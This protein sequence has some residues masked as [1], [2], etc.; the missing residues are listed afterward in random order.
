M[1]DERQNINI[2]VEPLR[3]RITS[4]LIPLLFAALLI[5]MLLSLARIPT[6]GFRPFMLLHA[7]F[8]GMSATLYFTRKRIRPDISALVMIGIL[9][10]LL[11]AGVASLG[12][13]SAT[14]VLGPMIALYLMLLG[15]RKSA[16]TSIVVILIYIS[17][18]GVLFVT[19]I[20]SSIAVPNSYSQSSTAWMLML[21]VV[22]SISVAAVSPFELVHGAL[23]ESE[24]RSRVLSEAAFEGIM[25]HDKGV[26]LDA[27][28][29]FVDLFGFHRPEDLIGLNGFEV[30]PFT[31][32][33]LERLKKSS[34]SN[35]REVIEITA[36]KPDGVISFAE[37]QGR[38]FITK[39][40]KLRV[41]S[42]RDITERKRTDQE[43]QAIYEIVEGVTTSVNLDELFKLIHRSL[44]KV[45]YVENCF[46]ALYDSNTRLFK[47]PY[48]VDKF[49]STPEPAALLKSCTSYVFRTGK[50]HLIPQAAFDRL[51]EQGE[52]ELVGSPSPSWIGVPLQTPSKTIGV[53]VLQHYEKENIYSERDL[54]FLATAGSEV[55][56]VI[57]RKLA[58]EALR[59]SEERMRAIVEGTPHLFFYTQDAE[60]N[61]T[62]VSPT[63]EQITGYKADIWLKRKDWFI[64]DAKINQSAKEKTY[65]HLQGEFAKEPTLIEVRHV[66][67]DP[68]LL[69]AYEYP[70]IQNGRVI[71]L[72]GV[73]H[74]ITKRKRVE[75][76]LRESEARFRQLAEVAVEGIAITEK[77]IFVD[78]NAR[79][80]AMLGY[81]LGEMIGKQV[82]DFIAPDSLA[83]VLGHISENYEGQY[84][85]FLLRKDGSTFPVES[86]A[87]TMMWRGRTMRV[88]VLLDISERKHAE[89]QLQKL[90]LAVGQSTASIVITDTKGNIEYVNPKFTQ[91]TGYTLEEAI[92]KNPRILK[93]GET[94]PEEYKRLWEMISSGKA[95]R[96]EF[97]NKK[98][99]GE[100][101]WEMASISPVKNKDNVI[102]N[103]V[104]V[105]ED[106]T[107]RKKLEEQVRQAQK[108]ESIGTLAGGI[109]H[110][111]NNI[112]G[113]ILGHSTLME[114]FKEDPQNLSRSIQAI[115]NATQ[116]GAG[117]V[118]Q[119]LTIARKTEA[120]F[121]NVSVNDI[122]R[123]I[124]KLLDETF[125]K[126][127][128]ISTSL[129][130]DLP[131]IVADAGQIHQVLLNL[132]VNARDAMPNRG[133]LSIST[134]IIEGEAVSSRFLK[135]T[136]RQYVQIEIADTGT[137]MDEATRQR[138]FEPFFTTKGLG[139]GTGLG[140]AVVFGIIGHHGGFIDVRSAPREG[141]TFAVYLP[142]PERALEEPR[143]ARKS[144]DVIAGG[145]ETILVIE[146]EEMLRNLAKAILISKGYQVLTAEDG[147][148]GV[149]MYRSHQDKI[150]VILSDIGLPS[151]SGQDVLKRIREINPKAKVV[152]A[153]GF[154]DPNTK[155]EMYK[156]GARHFIQKPYLPDEVLQTI[157]EVIDSNQ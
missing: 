65:A 145:T 110:D 70:I 7:L 144:I 46:V 99:N 146:D 95:W 77:G 71:A 48:F 123:E 133:T 59:E 61:N 74:D 54:N 105:K 152:M 8:L 153:S 12:L 94:S 22:G 91:V 151:L 79:L 42:M 80:A 45:L 4:R 66:N 55:A 124:I 154:F 76:A 84:E 1:K 93:S 130:Q 18:M 149:E 147:M 118:K 98:K 101:F 119:L 104:A 44:G 39:G 50:P 156:S 143:P 26:I 109:A 25:I 62:Y 20:L 56:L 28:Q 10:S 27:N 142:I 135:A 35:S 67:G 21:L 29:A 75:E 36:M 53:L 69:E 85:H 108:M 139:K 89:E 114:R 16:Y 72:Q 116:R 41:V 32:E 38:D 138:V 34:R 128:T 82:A 30:L 87:R 43:R 81:E 24:N 13:L 57:E 112:L 140:L 2:T 137:G 23:Q 19:G 83:V 88:T 129:Q 125:P 15:Y 97:H 6:I 86:H 49:D 52:V 37:T 107:E 148:L 155:S 126:T 117:I 51:V 120:L 106:I 33:S 136:A 141:T 9:F 115:T 127:I 131:L 40:G 73:V 113:I 92:G 11:I 14:F 103:F 78:G 17:V 132:C 47:F 157:R 3:N 60:G 90:S 150:A 31:P 58:E 121:E 134:R 111:F 96:G 5:N 64:T 122:I 68:I 102:T 100:L 63:I